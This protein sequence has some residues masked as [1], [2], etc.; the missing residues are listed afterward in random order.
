MDFS[1]FTSGKTTK[2]RKKIIPWHY[3]KRYQESISEISLN[4]SVTSALY[5]R[6][7][8]S[9]Q[10]NNKFLA[11]ALQ[12]HRSVITEKDNLMIENGK[13]IDIINFSRLKLMD[14][15]ELM[16]KAAPCLEE[17]LQMLNLR[18]SDNLSKNTH[19]NV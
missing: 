17:T 12:H 4:L 5:R 19:N 1:R 9:L 8:R 15:L 6:K 11:L 3:Q 7:I 13:S 10:K 16:K 18:I 2:F 14:M